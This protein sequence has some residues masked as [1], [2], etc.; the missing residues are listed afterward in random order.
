MHQI[1]EEDGYLLFFFFWDYTVQYRHSQRTYTHTPMNTHTQTLPLWSSSK[2][3]PTNPR[4]W[5]S[6]HRRL[7]V[8]G[9]V[10]YHWMHNAVKSQNIRSYG[11]VKP[12]IS[13]ATEALVTTRL[14]ALS[15]AYL[16]FMCVPANYLTAVILLPHDRTKFDACIHCTSN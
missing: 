7:T 3:E 12:R 6:H 15:H 9:N 4:D 2:T 13:G 8:D 11:G 14:H 10:A 16:L 5:Q 1:K